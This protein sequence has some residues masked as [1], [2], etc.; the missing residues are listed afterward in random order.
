LVAGGLL[1]RSFINLTSVRPGYDPAGVTTFKVSLPPG[2]ADA[3][4]RAFGEDLAA[5]LGAVPQVRAA[6]YGESLPLVRVARLGWLGTTAEMPR[7]P[8]AASR[9][10]TAGRSVSVRVVSRDFLK[11]MGTRI[12]SGRGFDESDGAG[13]PQVM[14]INQTLARS[15]FL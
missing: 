2:R 6:G 4:L 11:A 9:L 10:G 15:L 13:Q 12:V 8:E 1:I 5:R 14:L 7:D 3:Q